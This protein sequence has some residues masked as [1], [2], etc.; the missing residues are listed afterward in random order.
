MKVIESN[1]NG[2]LYV[3]VTEEPE[4]LEYQLRSTEGLARAQEITDK[5]EEISG[6]VKSVCETIYEKAFSALEEKKPAEFGIEFGIKLAGKAGIPL[7][8]EGSAECAVK[9]TAKW[10]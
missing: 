1:S 5:L 9:V 4:V 10:N 6:T 2:T 8:T 3:Q 7:L